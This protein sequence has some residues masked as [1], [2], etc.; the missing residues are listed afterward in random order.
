MTKM[1]L[2]E[3]ELFAPGITED[4]QPFWDWTAQ[5][6]L[7][8]QRCGACGRFRFPPLPACRTCGSLEASWEPVE[9]MPRL[10]SWVIVHRSVSRDVPVPYC[11]AVAEFADEVH[12]V[13]N[14]LFDSDEITPRAGMAL[15]VGFRELAGYFVPIFH[16]A[17]GRTD[18]DT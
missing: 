11:I 15:S 8:V 7:R 9:G 1:L 12:V 13:G 3:G 5:G 4:T 16:L 17:G 6:E 2:P 10:Y 18:D 14:L